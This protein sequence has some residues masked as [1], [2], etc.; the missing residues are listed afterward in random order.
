MDWSVLGSG[1]V[2]VGILLAA[3]AFLRAWFGDSTKLLKRLDVQQD[4]LARLEVEARKSL[5]REMDCLKRENASLIREADLK[6][7]VASCLRRIHRLESGTGIKAGDP[8]IGVMVIDL[9]GAVQVFSPTLA[10]PFKWRPIEVYG[11]QWTTLL[12][13]EDV[14]KAVRDFIDHQYHTIDPE[15]VYL[16]YG[17]DKYGDRFPVSVSLRGWQIGND[18]QVEMTI[19]ERI[20][21]EVKLETKTTTYTV[22]KPPESDTKDPELKRLPPLGG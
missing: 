2:V 5:E 18:G 21:A 4:Q 22:S 7:D 8:L 13:D 10:T 14:A 1:G 11:K 20:Q 9:N 12:P 16:T 19:Q 17:V 6:A 15:K 3:A